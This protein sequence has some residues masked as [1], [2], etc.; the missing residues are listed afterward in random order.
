MKDV[1]I[2][3]EHVPLLRG[4]LSASEV[5]SHRNVGEHGKIIYL[6]VDDITQAE[7]EVYDA[8]IAS[9]RSGMQRQTAVDNLQKLRDAMHP[10]VGKQL[11]RTGM[12]FSGRRYEILVDPV[13]ETVV[14]VSSGE[15]PDPLK[16][17]TG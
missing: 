11:L 2:A 10:Y 1:R 5:L 16:G 3:N 17:A 4:V 12:W 7:V 9:E 13:T 6:V 15:S 14:H 8:L